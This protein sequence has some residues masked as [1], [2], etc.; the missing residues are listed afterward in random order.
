MYCL[1]ACI[2][3]VINR[4]KK[5]HPLTQESIGNFLGIELK[6][7][8]AYYSGI[9]VDLAKIS[10]LFVKNGVDL[11]I[12]YLKAST[13]EEWQYIDFIEDSICQE[14]HLICTLAS[15]DLY[16]DVET[17]YGHAILI[18]GFTKKNILAID[19]DSK[20]KEIKEFSKETI[21]RASRHQDGG[22]IVFS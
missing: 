5:K 12:E 13:F 3:M 18:T 1:A 16:A 19:P 4:V 9:K 11:N 15:R 6:S 10:N 14:K 21:F 8:D 22:L 17:T 2:L 7:N 20:D